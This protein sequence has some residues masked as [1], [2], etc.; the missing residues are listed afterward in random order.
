MEYN[1]RT[2]GNYRM[3][4]IMEQY[5]I[6]GG[7]P[8]SGEVMIGGAKNAALGII[9]AAIMSDE[10]VTI[11]NIPDIRDINVLLEALDE[12]GVKVSRPN[13]HTVRIQADKINS[14][15]VDSDAIRKMRGS[16]YLIGALLG[17]YKE[18]QVALPGGCNTVS[19]RSCFADCVELLHLWLQ[20]I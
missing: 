1:E 9:A 16:Y 5:I 18:A 12:I 4:S 6:K 8:L 7:I 15:C 20:K 14:L 10:Q 19:S 11:E 2:F 13:R 17:K 3:G